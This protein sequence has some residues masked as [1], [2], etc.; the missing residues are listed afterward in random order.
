MPS[1]NRALHLVALI[2][3]LS[4][5]LGMSEPVTA[6]TIYQP[7]IS[8]SA[9]D[10][11][12][13]SCTAGEFVRGSCR[14]EPTKK[15]APTKKK[16]AAKKPSSSAPASRP[17]PATS[18]TETES[19]I[20][21]SDQNWLKKNGLVSP[22][23]AK[24]NVQA[25]KVLRANC[26]RSGM[27]TVPTPTGNLGL[28]VKVDTGITKL[29]NFF[30]E[31][32][33]NTVSLAWVMMVNVTAAM[34]AALEWSFSLNLMDEATLGSVGRQLKAVEAAW[35]AP[36][37]RMLMV[38]FGIWMIYNAAM[39]R[40]F[41]L[42][43]SE[44][45]SSLGLSLIV[46]MII[47]NP[48][49]TVG[50]VSQTANNLSLYALNAI[51]SPTSVVAK[52]KKSYANSYSEALGGVFDSVIVRSW[53]LL[54]FGDVYWATTPKELDS[55]LKDTAV[56]LAADKS[57]SVQ[58][59]VKE[60]KTNAALFLAFPPNTAERDGIN[61]I[62]GKKTLLRVLC[63]NSDATKCKGKYKAIANQRTAEGTD[64]RVGQWLLVASGL[65]CVWIVLGLLCVGLIGASIA[66]V[67]YLLLI[68]VMAPAAWF[69]WGGAKRKYQL[70]L[71]EFGGALF[72][73]LLYAVGL[74]VVIL[75]FNVIV[76]LQLSFF[77]QWILMIAAFIFLFRKR[78]ELVGFAP[79]VLT[80]GKAGR[81]SMRTIRRQRNQM[82]RRIRDRAVETRDKRQQRL[83]RLTASAAEESRQQ[84][85]SRRQETGA[86]S[87]SP[88]RSGEFAVAENP[89][90][91]IVET[92]RRRAI[93]MGH[94][95]NHDLRPL[96]ERLGRLSLQ[97]HSS[98]QKLKELTPGSPEHKK[99][100]RRQMSLQRRRQHVD[101]AVAT[102]HRDRQRGHDVASR[103]VDQAAEAARA[104]QIMKQQA[105]LPVTQRNYRQLAAM[106]E[107]TPEAY[108]QL[109]G[110]QRNHVRSLINQEL[111]TQH[112]S[113]PVAGGAAAGE[114]AANSTS[115]APAK[116]APR[117]GGDLQRERVSGKR[118]RPVP[119]RREAESSTR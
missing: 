22:V 76:A 109:D 56:D 43:L 74:G 71:M 72:A 104:S 31:A 54:Q 8:A 117:S 49:G 68:V 88:R 50:T 28:D 118:V 41:R 47:A 48:V 90:G 32:V 45:S 21:G 19:G 83:G 106:A 99:E 101:G 14:P 110:R 30:A 6:A 36:M 100:L 16:T 66:C 87:R 11:S 58:T 25:S 4:L 94:Q 84:R 115:P 10:R 24:A 3:L 2:T 9:V 37:V 46:L 39:R 12:G 62:D 75:L 27:A 23:C 116:R 105:A 52:S 51:Q 92:A 95:A 69:N 96:R 33:Q 42:A 112:S 114:F 63:D 113:T 13:K 67:F 34:F 81:R 93:G 5:T 15:K 107:L 102:A 80:P 73:K 18:S 77:K 59:A 108:D 103:P 89:A 82:S 119:R 57:P 29:G 86:T 78:K 7:Q 85:T 26:A 91:A 20:V 65:I 38:M 98:A 40:Q 97:E 64:A 55:E 70:Y 53:A 61:D 60:A 79:N 35:T 1:R 44:L 111:R 17:A